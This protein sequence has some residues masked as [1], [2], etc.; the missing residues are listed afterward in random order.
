MPSKREL[1]RFIHYF[2]LSTNELTPRCIAT[3]VAT[4]SSMKIA[5]M[6]SISERLG[7]LIEEL[8]L[9]EV[10]AAHGVRMVIIGTLCI[11]TTTSLP[12]MTV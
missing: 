3:T 12:I 6:I 4:L 2:P 7:N 5:K 10:N 11:C 1:V 8:R 9:K